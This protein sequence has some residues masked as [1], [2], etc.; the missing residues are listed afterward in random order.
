MFPIL[1]AFGLDIPALPIPSEYWTVL[2]I[3][4]GGYIGV[5]GIKTYSQAKFNSDRFFSVLRE[6][7]FTSGLTQEQVDEINRA[8]EEAK[9]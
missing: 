4:L 3:G 2:S 8:L 6:R 5:D 7:L 1:R 9:K